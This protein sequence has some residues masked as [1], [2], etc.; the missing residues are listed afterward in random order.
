MNERCIEWG[1][2]RWTLGYGKLSAPEKRRAGHEYAHRWAWEKFNGPIPKGMYILHRCDNPP[3]INPLHLRLGTHRDNMHDMLAKGRQNHQKMTCCR[4]C[5]SALY[6][7]GRQ[8]KCR[9]CYLAYLKGYYQKHRN[10][11]K[12]ERTS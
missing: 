12:V 8:R 3:C 10:V 7:N 4:K 2:S 6:H 9:A 11:P 1:G 5:G